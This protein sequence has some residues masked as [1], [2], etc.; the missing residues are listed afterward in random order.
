MTRRV[1]NASIFKR[2]QRE[3]RKDILTESIFDR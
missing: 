1:F 2:R 3:K